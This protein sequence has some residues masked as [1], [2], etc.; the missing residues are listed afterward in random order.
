MDS[1]Q[2]DTVLIVEDEKP[3]N[4]ILKDNFS[5]EGFE[6]LT[7]FNGQEGVDQAMQ[8]HPTIILLDVMMP[9]MDGVAVLKRIREVGDWGKNVPIIMLTNVNESEQISESMMYKVDKYWIKS[10]VQIG[11]LVKLVKEQLE[12]IRNIQP[13]I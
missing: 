13:Q 1:I 12:N 2:K 10:D 4:D 8:H 3:L 6:V 9:V 11:E 7:A 5:K